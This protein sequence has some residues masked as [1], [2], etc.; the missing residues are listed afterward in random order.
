[1][2]CLQTGITSMG[3]L[4]APQ[5]STVETTPLIIVLMGPP[6]AGKGTHAGPLSN[7]LQL[8]HISTGDL[9]REHI[10]NKTFLGLK[11]KEFMDKGHLVP[12]ELVLDIF[13][14]RMSRQDCKNGVLLD[15]FPRTVAQAEALDD[16]LNGSHCITLYFSIP[17]KLLLERITGRIACKSCGRPYH[18]KFDPPKEKGVCDHCRGALYQRDDDTEAVVRKRLEVYYRE[19]YSVIEYYAKKKGSFRQIESIGD[20]D[21]I[22]QEILKA[23]G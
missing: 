6:G 13:F 15:G 10:R 16:W 5:S 2:A 19:T 20:K 7:Y 22:F 4:L 3:S 14:D 11:A 9:F 8:P 17:D 1:M 18:V 23:I 21:A 12:D